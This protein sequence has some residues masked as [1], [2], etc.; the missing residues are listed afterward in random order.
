[1]KAVLGAIAVTFLM[2]TS[3]LAGPMSCVAEIGQLDQND[4]GFVTSNEATEF[5]G[6]MANVDV[7]GDGR[8]SPEEAVVACRAGTASEA[9]EA[10]AN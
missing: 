4:D 9:L 5:T 3:A 8:I 2:S 6:L 7:D 10:K 1:M